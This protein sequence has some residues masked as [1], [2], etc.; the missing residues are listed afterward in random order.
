[1]HLPVAGPWD[2]CQLNESATTTYASVTAED[3]QSVFHNL[4]R[5]VV[6]GEHSKGDCLTRHLANR[7]VC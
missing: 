7:Y 4:V 5:K 6:V 3:V 2:G 1:M